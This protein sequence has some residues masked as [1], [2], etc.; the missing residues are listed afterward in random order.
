[1][2]TPVD[3]YMALAPDWNGGLSVKRA[4]RT[5]IQTALNA[6]EIRSA[7]YTWPRRTIIMDICTDTAS[8]SAWLRGLIFKY[9]PRVWGIPFWQDG[10]VLTQAAA[11]G[12]TVL[13]V[14]DTSGRQYEVGAYAI[15]WSDVHTIEVVQIT[16]ITSGVLTLY[17]GLGSAWPTGTQVFPV[18]KSRIS[19]TQKMT[20]LTSGAGLRL[21]VEAAEEYDDSYTRYTPS[22]TS[23]YPAYLNYPVFG[24]PPDWNQA[25]DITTAHNYDQLKYLGKSYWLTNTTESLHTFSTVFLATSRTLAQQI[26]DFFDLRQGRF[27]PFWFPSWQEDIHLSGAQLATD[28][29]LNVSDSVFNAFWSGTASG[30]YIMIRWPDDTYVLRKVTST[31]LSSIT[32]DSALGKAISADIAPWML[33]SVLH[34]CRFDQ[35]EI[36]VRYMTTELANI[37][38]TLRTLPSET[39]V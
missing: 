35:D 9:L 26:T 38:L 33:I 28:T 19:A 21:K 8:N 7:L 2:S 32:I 34:F 36:E 13:S 27:A 4:W 15:L 22:A 23:V 3:A 20:P 24:F 29:V 5:G 30:R 1:M 10:S 25:S 14:D 12:A 39:P 17:A 16:A 11:Y 37:T 6:S 18:L 31:S